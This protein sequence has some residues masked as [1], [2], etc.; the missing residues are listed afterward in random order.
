M[1]AGSNE[2]PAPL[3]DFGQYATSSDH[4]ARYCAV[5]RTRRFFPSGHGNRRQYSLHLF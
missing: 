5:H 4:R 1:S 2:Q 3:T